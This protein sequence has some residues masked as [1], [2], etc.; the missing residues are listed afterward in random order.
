MGT[1]ALM[2]A[3]YGGYDGLVEMLLEK[4]ADPSITD[5]SGKKAGDYYVVRNSNEQLIKKLA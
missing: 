4:G 1:T 3:A 2:R 5:R